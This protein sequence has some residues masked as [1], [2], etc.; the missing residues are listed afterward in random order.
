MNL[1]QPHFIAALTLA[2]VPILLHLIKRQKAKKVILGSLWL[3]HRKRHNLPKKLKFTQILLLATRVGLAL[4]LAVY[5]LKP[6]VLKS[7][8]WL[9]QLLP[10][11]QKITVFLDTDLDT[12][13]DLVDFFMQEA[14]IEATESIQFL[15]LP[16]S[17][18]HREGLLKAVHNTR[19]NAKH[20]E[21]LISRFYG[22]TGEVI[23]ALK[24]EGIN[25]IPFG[26]DR[27]QTSQ[28][29]ELSIEP[30]SPFPDEKVTVHGTIES[31]VTTSLNLELW[32]GTHLS[33]K[34]PLTATSNLPVPFTLEESINLHTGTSVELR[35]TQDLSLPEATT[36]LQRVILPIKPRT[37]MKIGLVDDKADPK[38]RPSRLYAIHEFIQS[39]VSLYETRAPILIR[40]LRSQDLIELKESYDFLI[41]GDMEQSVRIPA[42]MP[43]LIFFQKIPSVQQ[44]LNEAME[45]TTWDMRRQSVNVQFLPLHT[46][47]RSL[48]DRMFK[49]DN[50]LQFKA[51]QSQTLALAGD[52]PL[53]VRKGMH[54]F[55]GINFTNNEFDGLRHPY[56]PIFLYRILL[57]RIEEKS[58]VFSGNQ[59]KQE[60]LVEI[61]Q[62]VNSAFAAPSEQ[63]DL[64]PVFLIFVLLFS[65]IE[66]GL[67]LS[68]QK[69]NP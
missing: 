54:V 66:L 56:F 26:P 32:Q 39:L 55:S 30:D 21:W 3:L 37:Q 58:V 6:I 25:L 62:I 40:H 64:S 63:S 9:G 12:K 2:L 8:K 5:F 27:I 49:A 69:I 29:R 17:S 22:I 10:V 15:E 16:Q 14:K 68:L 53:I 45:I 42:H 20:T 50:T 41:V 34:I 33:R 43:A 7:P 35:L 51:P 18:I 38:T 65:I 59:N 44:S 31:N 19:I 48:L 57:N 13:S 67:V 60:R 1:L 61:P 11:E 46:M 36:L 47:D 52:E 28:F 23:D 4:A 24:Q